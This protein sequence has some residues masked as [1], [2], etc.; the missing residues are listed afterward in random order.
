MF[1]IYIYKASFEILKM[2]QLIKNKEINE[3]DDEDFGLQHNISSLSNSSIL[4]ILPPNYWEKLKPSSVQENSSPLEFRTL[5]KSGKDRE[6]TTS[7]LYPK[8]KKNHQSSQHI[9]YS[10]FI[11]LLSVCS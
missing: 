3:I 7:E 6:D 8:N 4:E 11:F 2:W 9:L 5:W 10:H 1:H